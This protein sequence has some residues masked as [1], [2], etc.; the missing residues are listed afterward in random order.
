MSI[1][2]FFW[3]ISLLVVIIALSACKPAHTVPPPVDMVG[4]SVSAALT[5]IPPRPAS[6]PYPTYTPYPTPDLSGLFCEYQFCISHPADTPFFDLEVVNK[7]FTNHS[8]YTQGNLIGFID[9]QIFIFMVWSQI[10]GEFDPN[11][12]ITLVLNGDQTDGILITTDINGRSVSYMLLSS[13]P[14]P[15]I[16]PYGLAAAWQCDDR[17]FGW[18]IYTTQDGQGNDYLRQAMSQFTCLAH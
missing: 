17:Q 18:K 15:D 7:D 16:L 8:S 9:Q 6:T 4:T 11:R 13:T 10:T 3:T 1:R 12:M 2:R 14:S 5:A